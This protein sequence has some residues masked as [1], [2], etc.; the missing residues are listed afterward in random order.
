MPPFPR[1]WLAVILV[2]AIGIPLLQPLIP[3]LVSDYRLFLVSTM[4]IAGRVWN[5][6]VMRSSTAASGPR[7]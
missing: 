1:K 7:K 6:S 5:R 3:D 2:L 4:M